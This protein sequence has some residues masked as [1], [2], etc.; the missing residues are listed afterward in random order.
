[1]HVLTEL[2]KCMQIRNPNHYQDIDLLSLQ[3]VPSCSFPVYPSFLR[4]KANH[5]SNFSTI[6]LF[7]LALHRNGVTQNELF[8]VRL[9]SFNIVVCKS[10]MLLHGSVVLK[11]ITEWYFIS[12]YQFAFWFPYWLM[13]KLFLVLGYH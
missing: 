13:P 10:S 5:C 6:L 11:K 12:K 4:P 3:E 8:W 1:M 7:V 9:T 2:H